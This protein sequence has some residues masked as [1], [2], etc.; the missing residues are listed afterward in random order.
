MAK[1]AVPEALRI[2]TGEQTISFDIVKA[3][4][5]FTIEGEAFSL[6][7]YQPEAVPPSLTTLA[8]PAYAKVTVLTPNLKRTSH[9]TTASQDHS[10]LRVKAQVRALNFTRIAPQGRQPT[11]FYLLLFTPFLVV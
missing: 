4:Y 11:S 1:R 2:N 6:L 5:P 3:C 8:P 7:C 10:H 9:S